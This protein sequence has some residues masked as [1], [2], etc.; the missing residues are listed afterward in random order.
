MIPEP[1]PKKTV[2]MEKM[3]IPQKNRD[4]KCPG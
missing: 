2:P 1:N 3:N 4:S